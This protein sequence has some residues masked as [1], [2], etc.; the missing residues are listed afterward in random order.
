ME[1]LLDKKVYV[2]ND[3]N[4][5][6]WGEYLAGSGKGTDSMVMIT[7]GTGIGSGIIDGGHLITG[8]YGKGAHL[9]SM[10]EIASH[11]GMSKETVKRALVALRDKGYI[12]SC[13]GKGY[14][15]ARDITLIPQKP[16]SL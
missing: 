7:L 8:A 16:N 11:T 4:A 15:V 1:K 10:A 5:A 2:E 3:A 9:P 13:P 6:A 12:A 14:Y